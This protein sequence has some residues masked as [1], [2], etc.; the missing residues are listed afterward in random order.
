MSLFPCDPA[1]ASAAAGPPTQLAY[2]L[3]TSGSTGKPKGCALERRNLAHY[4]DF[5]TSAYFGAGGGTMGLYTSLAFDLTLTSLFC[6][7]VL[8]R[9]LHLLPGD[10]LESLRIMFGESPDM[11]AVKMTPAHIGLLPESWVSAIPRFARLSP[12]VRP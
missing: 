10:A 4:I 1:R 2:V 11:D 8:G 9:P 5:A 7:L 3:Y 6:P 12:A